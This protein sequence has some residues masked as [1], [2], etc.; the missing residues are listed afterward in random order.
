MLQR[1]GGSSGGSWIGR[2]WRE[3]TRRDPSEFLQLIETA[4][5]D[6]S[7][8]SLAWLREWLKRPSHT[9]NPRGSFYFLLPPFAA[10]P[11]C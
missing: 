4:G 9:C 11:N 6:G 1:S 10:S 8:Q 5:L 3:P 7:R 2:L